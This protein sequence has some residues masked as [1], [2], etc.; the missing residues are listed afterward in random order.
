MYIVYIT[1]NDQQ[2]FI[3]VNV[4]VYHRTHIQYK[5]VV[6]NNDGCVVRW[7]EGENVSLE[8]P[9]GSAEAMALDVEDSWNKSKQVCMHLHLLIRALMKLHCRMHCCQVCVLDSVC[10]RMHALCMLG[11]PVHCTTSALV[12]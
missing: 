11:T 1:A 4:I 12:F 7:Q 8:L 9:G 5:Y 2:E 3:I 10:F 6:R